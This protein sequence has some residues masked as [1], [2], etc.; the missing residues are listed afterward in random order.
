MRRVGDFRQPR[1]F[2]REHADLVGPAEAVLERAQDAILVAALALEA[3]HRVDHMLEHARPGD[4]A[5]LGDVADQHHRGAALLG[6]ADQLL[7]RGADLADRPRRA[8]DQ[9]ANASSG[10]N[11]SPAAPAAARCRRVVRMSRTEVAA[12]SWTGA[13][14]EPEPHRAQPHLVGRFLARD[15]DDALP[16]ERQLAPRPGAAGSTCRSPDRRRPASPTRR[17]SRRRSRGR[18]RRSRSAAARA[19]RPRRR[20]RPARPPARRSTDRAAPRRR[21]TTALSW[22]S[23]FHSAQSA[24]CPCQRLCS[25]PQAWHT[26]RVLGLAMWTPA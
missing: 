9:V 15:I 11:R 12:A 26:Y 2:H 5:V 13:S 1:P 25:D 24:H 22:T 4:R 14:A 3:E 8:L 20:A 10:S 6:E 19:A 23:V 16:V 7:R 18:T 21:V 17:R